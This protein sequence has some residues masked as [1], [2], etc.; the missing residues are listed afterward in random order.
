MSWGSESVDSSCRQLFTDCLSEKRVQKLETGQQLEEI[1][2]LKGIYFKIMDMP[3]QKEREQPKSTD[4]AKRIKQWETEACEELALVKE[5]EEGWRTI[6][7][8]NL[9]M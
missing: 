6:A 4:L 1:V 9:V 2:R 5:G 7:I 8:S 3:E